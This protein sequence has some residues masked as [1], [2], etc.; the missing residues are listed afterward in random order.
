M[1]YKV[2]YRSIEVGKDGIF[3]LFEGEGV[4]VFDFAEHERAVYRPYAVDL[5]QDAQQEFLV[6]LHVLGVDL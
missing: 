1:R 2:L 6:F 4:V 5:P 3:L